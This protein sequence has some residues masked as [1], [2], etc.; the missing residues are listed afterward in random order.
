MTVMN[1]GSTSILSGMTQDVDVLPPATASVPGRP[2]QVSRRFRRCVG[3]LITAVVLVPISAIGVLW[4]L[5]PFVGDAEKRIA[6]RLA[7]HGAKDPGALPRPDEVRV[8]V[9]LLPWR[10]A[11]SR[12]LPP[13]PASNAPTPAPATAPRRSRSVRV[14]FGVLVQLDQASGGKPH[15]QSPCSSISRTSTSWHRRQR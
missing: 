8:A 14:S 13:S 4:P 10:A 1:T 7:S 11:G 5:M 9:M 12:A 6:A 3:G 15:R 2:G